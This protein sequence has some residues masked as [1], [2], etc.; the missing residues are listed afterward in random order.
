MWATVSTAARRTEVL[1]SRDLAEI[2]SKVFALDL[3]DLHQVF[4]KLAKVQWPKCLHVDDYDGEAY[5]ADDFVEVVQR[6]GGAQVFNKMVEDEYKR[7]L[8]IKCVEGI[9]SRKQISDT[10]SIW[11]QAVSHASLSKSF[12][13]LIVSAP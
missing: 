11:L 4:E 7:F 9:A 8:V 1:T 6:V 3:S 5:T 10:D 12:G 2:K 13:R